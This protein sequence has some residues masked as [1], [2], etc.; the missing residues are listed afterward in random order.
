MA[1]YVAL[2][3]GINVGGNNK[4]P[5]AD[6]RRALEID[7]FE[8]VR[9]YIQS[10]NVIFDSRKAT[11]E[12]LVNRVRAVISSEFALDI[13]TIVMDGAFLARV[14]ART[15]YPD[16]ADPRR[17]HVFFLSS[18]LDAASLTRL[19]ELQAGVQAKGSNDTLTC[20]GAVMYLHTPDGFG[21]SDLAKALSTRGPGIHRSGTARNWATVTKLV[22]MCG[23]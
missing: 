1:C 20:D 14:V 10:G 2:L 23:A 11:S 12:A 15:P 18:A 8:R 22:E 5:M 7:G 9:T 13:A 3:R 16:E 17:V 6:L 19:D 4:I 21:T